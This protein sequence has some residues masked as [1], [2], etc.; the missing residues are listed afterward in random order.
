MFDLGGVVLGS[1]LQG[2]AEYEAARGIPAGFINVSISARGRAGA[3][4]RLER[5]ELGLEAFY[6]EFRT[7]LGDAGAV[8]QF[9]DYLLRKGREVPAGMPAR[10]DIDTRVLF[11]DYMMR[12][13]AQVSEDMCHALF[14]LRGLGYRV[15]ALTNNWKMGGDDED[16]SSTTRL[17][18]FFD[19]VLES[20]VVGLRKPD[21]R[22]YAL[23]TKELGVPA[24]KTVFLDDIGANLKAAK[25]HGWATIKVEIGMVRDAIAQLADAL[26]LPPAQLLP[27]GAASLH[28]PARLAFPAGVD[29]GTLTMD[30]FV[31][32]LLP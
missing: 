20:S 22:I 15:A 27:P 21:P 5:G 9:E 2:I 6:A 1:P 16:S 18:S 7:E 30:A 10:F 31:R 32:W 28:V 19:L 13:A 8:G 12:R 25:A 24:H 17:A 4:Q 26:G 29:G 11:D 23:A 3:F 14:V